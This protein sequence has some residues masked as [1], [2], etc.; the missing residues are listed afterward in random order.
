MMMV[1]AR[2]ALVAFLQLFAQWLLLMGSLLP[3]FAGLF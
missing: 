3:V 2:A 1:R